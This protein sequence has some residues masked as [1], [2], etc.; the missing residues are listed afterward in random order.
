MSDAA[1]TVS[2]FKERIFPVLF[3]LLVTV[4]FIAVVSGI[5]L[6][7]R[8]N[9]LRN[10]QL[11]LKRAVLF[12]AGLSVPNDAEGQ[13]DI[14][15]NVVVEVRDKEENLLYYEI[16]S[17]GDVTGYVFLS[18]GAGLWGEIETVVGMDAE[19]G[20][21]TGVDFTKQNETP[22]LGARITEEWFKL[23]FQ[24][25]K[26]PLSTV[27]EGT[28]DNSDTEFDAITGATQT[29]NAVQQIVNRTI[30]TAPEI[31]GRE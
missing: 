3:M 18:V 14:Y 27:P 28:E 16:T 13:D 19:L 4:V 31:I 8:D 12:A 20:R 30:E 22:G 7:T 1:P 15:N 5:H 2:F 23:Q 24:G 11:Y 29:S 9:V 17:N 21:L 25:K 26:G 6:A 10:E